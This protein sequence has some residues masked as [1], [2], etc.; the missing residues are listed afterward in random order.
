MKYLTRTYYAI[1]HML[2]PQTRKLYLVLLM[3]TTLGLSA[4]EFVPYASAD[5]I[6]ITNNNTLETEVTTANSFN[7][8]LEFDF[9][10]TE[11]GY[12]R[13]S[14]IRYSFETLSTKDATTFCNNA[15]ITANNKIYAKFKKVSIPKKTQAFLDN[16][17]PLSI[18]VMNITGIPASVCLA[19]G[20]LESNSGT[21]VA[22]RKSK[23][24]FNVWATGAKKVA[25][26]ALG[27]PLH[28]QHDEGEYR[29][30]YGGKTLR[31]HYLDIY[32]DYMTGTGI[33]KG[34]K[35]YNACFNFGY[36]DY[37][38]WCR[39][40][41][42][43]GYATDP[44]YVSSLIK[45]IEDYKLYYYDNYYWNNLQVADRFEVIYAIDASTLKFSAPYNKDASK[46]RRKISGYVNVEMN[47]WYKRKA[48]RAEKR[49]LGRKVS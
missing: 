17:A 26:K 14:Y 36:G 29:Q 23:V 43:K 31:Q 19:Q 11:E 4:Q 6:V 44:L 8:E 9:T 46:K 24:I 15:Y 10:I 27:I 16:N 22:A 20:I 12:V 21:C 1:M 32:A 41:Y 28:T 49:K 33:F 3:F 30:F 42:W 37:K 39:C 25:A 13:Q 48:I 18:E 2:E 47:N 40:V 7:K 5:K 34:G 35:R 45:I 38:D